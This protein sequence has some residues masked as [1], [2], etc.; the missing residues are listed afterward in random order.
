MAPKAPSAG[1]LP[2]PERYA[3][4][5]LVVQGREDSFADNQDLMDINVNVNPRRKPA[6]QRGWIAERAGVPEQRRVHEITRAE[7]AR[8]RQS[9]HQLAPESADAVWLLGDGDDG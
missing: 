7:A 3:P 5:D 4:E 2:G 1:C 6:H 8:D 9:R